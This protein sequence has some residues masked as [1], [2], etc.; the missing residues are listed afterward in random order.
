MFS[1]V[2]ERIG[3]H[4]FIAIDR[5]GSGELVVFLHGIGG[6]KTNWREQLPK[7]AEHFCAVAWDARGY[8]ES[9]DYEEP[10][11]FYDYARDLVR[12]LDHCRAARAHIVGLSMGGRIALDFAEHYPQRLLTLTICATHQGYAHFSEEQKQDFIRLRRD[13]L[14]RGGEPRDIADSVAKSLIGPKASAEAYAQLVDS[15]SKLR[16]QSYLKSI[17]ATVRSPGHER[18]A[19][20]E[21]PT[22]V[23][24]GGADRLVTPEMARRIA[25]LIPRSRFSLL[26]DAGHLLNIEFPA[27]FN[28]A[29]LG[30]ILHHHERNAPPPTRLMSAAQSGG[31]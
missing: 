4:P 5:A 29:V 27:E 23:V 30:F 13:P 26:P 21:A 2:T 7:F 10:L 19:E 8:G 3:P 17:E 6:N 12:V 25:D 16:K 14:I 11:H 31:S 15:L 18:L 20:I 22:H 1:I 28:A 9:D 24:A